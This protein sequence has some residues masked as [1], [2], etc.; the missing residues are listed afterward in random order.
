MRDE[1]QRAEDDGARQ[2][3]LRVLHLAG[4]ERQV[5][6]AVV[7]PQHA[8]ERQARCCRPR[9]A[10]PAAGAVRCDTLAPWPPPSR[11]DAP[12]STASAANLAAVDD[13][14]DG[15][16]DVGAEDVGAGGEGDG[17]GRQ[18]A[19][20]RCSA[21]PDRRR[22]CAAGIRRRRPAMPPRAEARISTSSDQ[23]NRTPTGR[24]QPSRR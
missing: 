10:A 7:G 21:R 15:R 18:A 22:G 9:S 19:G 5:A 3:A 2:V 24:P 4:G 20:E 8:D 12:T 17:G 23:P 13:A 11:N 14:D 16:A 1:R 6:P